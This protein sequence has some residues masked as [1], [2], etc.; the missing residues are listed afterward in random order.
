MPERDIFLNVARTRAGAPLARKDAGAPLA[1]KAARPRPG[2]VA[3]SVPPRGGRVVAVNVSRGGVPKLPIQAATVGQLGLAGDCH[4]EP[5]PSHGGPD[6]AVCLYSAEAIERVVADG[7]RSFPG[8]FGENLTVSGIEFGGLQAGDRLQFG[9][10]GPL[11]QLT[12]YAAP[13]KTIAHYFVGGRFGRIS[14]TAHPED[15]RWYARVLAEGTV[16]TGDA[17]AVVE[18]AESAPGGP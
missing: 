16:R 2:P 4:D 8:A 15:A 11:L 12:K 5:E 6:Q 14:P 17:V 7:H 9:A 10:G 1:S 3:V 18:P 13:C